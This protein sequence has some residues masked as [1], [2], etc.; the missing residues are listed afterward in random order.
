MNSRK[1]EGPCFLLL[2]VAKNDITSTSSVLAVMILPKC[3]NNH[4]CADMEDWTDQSLPRPYNAKN[5]IRFIYS[6]DQ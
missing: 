3:K 1:H 6:M 2:G 5:T 4:G